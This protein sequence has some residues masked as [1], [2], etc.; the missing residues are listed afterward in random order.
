MGDLPAASQWSPVTTW[1]AKDGTKFNE[2]RSE[3]KRLMNRLHKGEKGLTLIELLV[4]IAILGILTAVAVPMVIGFIE[5]GRVEA[6]ASELRAVQLAVNAA[7]ARAGVG[8]VT[9]NNTMGIPVDMGPPL[10][11]S[12]T[13]NV[14]FDGVAVNATVGQF[15]T[16]GIA[17]LEGTYSL[18]DNATVTMTAFPGLSAPFPAP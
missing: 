10:T 2:R 16:G 7:M 12:K 18:A 5:G 11:I 1:Q 3:M 17:A 14:R 9:A 6:A 4:V 8:R 13:Q 15:L